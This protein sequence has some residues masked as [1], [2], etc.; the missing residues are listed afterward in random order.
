MTDPLFH[1]SCG[2][3]FRG[4]VGSQTAHLRSKGEHAAISARKWR[5]DQ[6]FR[7]S[8]EGEPR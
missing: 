2:A 7:K 8:L 3:R 6:L 1:C 5:W 4:N